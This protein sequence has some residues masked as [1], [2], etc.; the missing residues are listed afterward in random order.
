M[1]PEGLEPP[2]V[3]P[4]DPK[5]CA[6]TSSA[7]VAGLSCFNLRA[8]HSARERLIVPELCRSV[9]APIAR[10]RPGDSPATHAAVQLAEPA[11]PRPKGRPVSCQPPAS[12]R[13]GSRCP[14]DYLGGRN[15]LP[16]VPA[17]FWDKPPAN[18]LR[19]SALMTR[20]AGAL[21]RDLCK[22]FGKNEG[23]RTYRSWGRAILD[24][25]D[26]LAD[27]SGWRHAGVIPAH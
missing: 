8:P 7:T 17:A 19:Y 12:V 13:G 5:S 10:T 2:R 21:R 6:S 1:R 22:W 27:P 25:F 15:E 20:I 23:E 18:A 26:A 3:A 11:P 24:V 4:Q 9:A 14:E 16:Y